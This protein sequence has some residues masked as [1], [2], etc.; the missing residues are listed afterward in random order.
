MSRLEKI[1]FIAAILA[2]SWMCESHASAR[3]ARPNTHWN[4]AQHQAFKDCMHTKSK[5][6][7]FAC[8]SVYAANFIN[9][10]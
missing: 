10:R 4:A 2:V 9:N 7:Q 3:H 6:A 5:Q 8:E 1:M